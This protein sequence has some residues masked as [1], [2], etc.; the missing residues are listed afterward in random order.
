MCIKWLV[1]VCAI[2]VSV[3][4]RQ[5]Y[6][7]NGTVWKNELEKCGSGGYETRKINFNIGTLGSM[8]GLQY[9]DVS[10]S[11]V[12]D[13][14]GYFELL[15]STGSEVDSHL[16]LENA[17]DATD[18]K[19]FSQNWSRATSSG[20]ASQTAAISLTLKIHKE[21]AI[22]LVSEMYAYSMLAVTCAHANASVETIEIIV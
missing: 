21:G 16:R 13:A 3:E 18:H 11:T 19:S 14:R 6:V 12:V 22:E 10:T 9:D 8:P 15:T 4:C 5:S 20:F 17:D 2:V 1:V 7:I